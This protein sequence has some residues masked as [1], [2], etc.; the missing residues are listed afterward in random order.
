[1]LTQCDVKR[2]VVH[3]GYQREKWIRKPPEHYRDDDIGNMKHLELLFTGKICGHYIKYWISKNIYCE[4]FSFISD[5]DV[6][7]INEL[8]STAGVH[9]SLPWAATI[10]PNVHELLIRQA[11]T[12]SSLDSFSKKVPRKFGCLRNVDIDT[13]FFLS[14]KCFHKILEKKKNKLEFYHISKHYKKSSDF[15]SLSR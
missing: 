14:Q 1:M 11:P 5:H 4:T 13:F 3:L 15:S 7:A 6:D 2:F 10:L 9:K 8:V 12:Y